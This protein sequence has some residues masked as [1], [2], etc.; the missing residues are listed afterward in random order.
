MAAP[1]KTRRSD[2]GLMT[3]QVDAVLRASRAL[4][5]IAATSLAAVEDVVTVPQWRVLVLVHTRGP[6]NLASV[7]AELDVNPSNASRTCDRLTRAGLLNR[8]EAE[9]DRR[10]VT[11]TLTAAG[12]RLVQ[13][14]TRQRRTA[15]EKVLA[16]MPVGD[17]D[18][19]A[20]ALEV[21]A[22]AAGEKPDGGRVVAA[23]WPPPR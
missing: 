14:V 7:A 17:R 12:R 20:D 1:Q 21:F 22:A 5:G 15:I 10:N 2:N 18:R 23:L 4:V 8:R 6:M 19:L 11:L 16:T 3:D 9:F 13:K